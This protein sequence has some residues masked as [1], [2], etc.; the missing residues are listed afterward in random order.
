MNSLRKLTSLLTDFLSWYFITLSLIIN[1]WINCC[2]Y[3][4]NIALDPVLP[5]TE[6]GS[7]EFIDYTLRVSWTFLGLHWGGS[8]DHFT[9]NHF[10][11]N[12]RFQ[13]KF[14]PHGRKMVAMVAGPPPL[15]ERRCFFWPGNEKI[16][17]AKA[18]TS[19]VLEE[20]S[21]IIS[22]PLWSWRSLFGLNETCCH[23]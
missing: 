5:V 4:S 13:A 12:G 9:T 18:K 1:V 6:S 15:Q 16:L 20:L 11:E 21:C 14:D 7:D 23:E 10:D 19:R 2:L 3:L 17:V 8:G 22:L